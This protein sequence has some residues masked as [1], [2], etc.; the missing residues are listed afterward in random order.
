MAWIVRIRIAK[1]MPVID[2]RLV[3]KPVLSDMYRIIAI[4]NRMGG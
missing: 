3:E 1:L 4:A 2:C